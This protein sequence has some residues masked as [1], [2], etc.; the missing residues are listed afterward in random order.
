MNNLRPGVSRRRPRGALEAHGRC[1]GVNMGTP[2]SSLR[3]VCRAARRRGSAGAPE[4]R[5]AGAPERRSTGSQ[6]RCF[7]DAML[8][9]C[10]ALRMQYYAVLKHCKDGAKD[11]VRWRPVPCTVPFIVSIVVATMATLTAPI[12]ATITADPHGHQRDNHSAHHRDGAGRCGQAVNPHG[13]CRGTR[14]LTEDGTRRLDPLG[15]KARRRLPTGRSVRKA[16]GPGTK[17]GRSCS[18]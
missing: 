10:D 7:A 17:E 18:S 12:N 13:Y 14:E 5:S 15:R 11:L 9:G 6:G 2:G 8:R 16:H 1:I 4:R 3:R